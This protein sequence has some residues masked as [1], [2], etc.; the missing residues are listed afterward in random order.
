M[1]HGG[2]SGMSIIKPSLAQLS[3]AVFSVDPVTKD[4]PLC[5]GSDRVSGLRIGLEI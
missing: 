4:D 3:S 5:R 2:I 1:H